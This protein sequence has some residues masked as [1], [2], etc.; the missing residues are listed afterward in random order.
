MSESVGYGYL[1]KNDYKEKDSQPDYKGKCTVKTVEYDI[2]GW[3]KEKKGRK[4]IS[5]SFNIPWEGEKEE[6]TAGSH[7]EHPEDD[8][9]F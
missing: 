1:G 2:G 6:P 3:I 9:P 5:L 7:T 4:Y 8:I